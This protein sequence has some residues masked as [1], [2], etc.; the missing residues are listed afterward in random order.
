MTR[1]VLFVC[2]GNI[3]RSP[4]AEALLK[5]KEGFNVRSAGTWIGAPRRIS[6]DLV[7]WADTIFVMEEDHKEVILSMRPDAEGKIVVLDVPNMY[8]R[9]DPELN[10][11]LK[12]KLSSHLS[13]EW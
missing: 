12:A 2:T 4:T 10:R 3:D 6:R 9:G 8:S 1:K 7:D 5:T 11:T 13:I